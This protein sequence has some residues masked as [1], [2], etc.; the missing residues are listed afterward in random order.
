M[1]RFSDYQEVEVDLNVDVDEYFEEMDDHERQEMYD[2]LVKNGYG[3]GEG[4]PSGRSSWEFDS[5][6]GKLK[7]NYLALTNDETDLIIKLA[8]RF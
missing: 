1:P 7:Q 8:K 6:I 5:A 3:F 2:L 4:T